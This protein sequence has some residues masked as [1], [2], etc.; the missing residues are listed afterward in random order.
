MRFA[1]TGI[2]GSF[3]IHLD[4][5]SD[6]R[7]NFIRLFDADS[8]AAHGL[9]SVFVQTGLS[10]TTRAGSVRGLHFQRPPFE[11]V[12]LV[13]CMR[14]AVFD[15]VVDLRPDSPTHGQ[16]RAATLRE[17]DDLLVAIPAGCAHGFQTLTDGT[18]LLY[19]ISAPYSPSH[20]DGVRFDDPAFG[21]AWPRPA[22]SLSER[23][24]AWPL[25]RT[26][27]ALPLS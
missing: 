13:R 26:A 14:G 7:G 21:I 8:F 15:V 23:D 12:K 18:D 9:P 19:H 22:G 17:D 20:A 27:V 2:A 3:L 10:A 6:E 16:W 24:R 5:H 25:I 11:E 1:P 4:R